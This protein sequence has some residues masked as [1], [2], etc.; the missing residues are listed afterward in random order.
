MPTVMTHAVVGAGLGTLFTS[1]KMPP[2]FWITTA[3]L[4]MA[5]DLD[6][7]AF[8]LGIP[9][10]MPLGHRGFTHSLLFALLAGLTAALLTHPRIGGRRADLCGFFFLVTASH[11]LLDAF[12]NGGMGV[13]FFIPFD[14]RRYFFPWHPIQ[15][16]PIGFAFFSREGGAVILSEMLWVWLPTAAVVA[17]VWLF[18]RWRRAEPRR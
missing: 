10:E 15:V 13:G 5:P 4:A 12:T 18:R 16:S 3:A 9:Y 6:V 2:M 1:R 8:R 11:G 7:W 14:T 17:S